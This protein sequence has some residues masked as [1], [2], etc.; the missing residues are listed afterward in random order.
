MGTRQFTAVILITALLAPSAGFAQSMADG[1]PSQALGAERARYFDEASLRR[2]VAALQD[3]PA[4][5]TAPCD[6]SRSKGQLDAEARHGTA[7]WMLGGLGMGVGLG[8]IGMG[9]MGAASGLSNPQPK[10]VPPSVDE[11]CYR[12]GYS[13]TA[14]RRNVISSVIGSGIGVGVFLVILTASNSS[15]LK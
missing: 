9:V 7:G 3:Q 12:A 1:S 15:L 11:S 2:H 13:G 6:N 10:M 8:L 5:A 14:K 4:S